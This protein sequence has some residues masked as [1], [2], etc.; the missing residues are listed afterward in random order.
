M[1]RGQSLTA[2]SE[3]DTLVLDNIGALV[4]L[5]SFGHVE[6]TLSSP[7]Q[8]EGGFLPAL[9]RALSGKEMSHRPAGEPDPLIE[10]AAG[11]SY[12]SGA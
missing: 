3:S 11:A 7:L 9:E 10:H 4:F 8:A 5:G 6:E 12:H 1:P 2:K